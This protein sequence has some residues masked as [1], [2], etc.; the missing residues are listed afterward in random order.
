MRLLLLIIFCI[1]ILAA[2][3]P[4]EREVD[5]GIFEDH[6]GRDACCAEQ[7]K[8]TPHIM[9]VGHWD[10]RDGQCGFKC[11]TEPI[12]D[13]PP[14]DEVQ[15]N[16]LVQETCDAMNPCQVGECYKFED[17]KSPVCYEGDPCER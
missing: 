16:D 13:E 12:D 15:D 7:N 14:V 1:L 10:Y 3:Q 9:C 2:C 6:E 11:E 17:R 4:I 5:C 8:D